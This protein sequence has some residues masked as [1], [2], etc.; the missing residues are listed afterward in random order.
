MS[1]G[2]PPKAIIK[3]EEPL[4]NEIS[5]SIDP[6]LLKNVPKAQRVELF[7]QIKMSRTHS[8]PLPSPETLEEYSRLINNG[9]ERIMVMA[10]KQSAH[11]MALER[12]FMNS[13]IWQGFIGQIFGLIVGLSAIGAAVYCATIDQPVLGSILGATGITG[14]VTAFIKGRNSQLQEI[15][16]KR[17][18]TKPKNK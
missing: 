11:R 10:E 3:E 6:E 8:G 2:K 4:E 1:E 16:D 9:A 13:N 17:Q 15:E 14:L 7:R 5:K 18:T 12:K